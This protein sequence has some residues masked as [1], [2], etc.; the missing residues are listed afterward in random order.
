MKQLSGFYRHDVLRLVEDRSADL[1]GVELGVAEGVFSERMI[2]SGKFRHFFGVDL[3]SDHRHDVAEYKR[4]LQRV[5]LL[6]NYRLLRMSFDEAYDLFDDA[7]LDFVYVDGYAHTGEEGGDTI[8]KWYR[9]VRQGGVIAGDDYHPDWPLVVEAANRFAA[10]A[11]EDLLVTDLTE[12]QEFCRYPTWAIVKKGVRTPSTP[13]HLAAAG[14][15]A[16]VRAERQ[17]ARRRALKNLATGL[18][19]DWVRTRLRRGGGDR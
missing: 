1:I 18:L 5:G 4:A 16:R 2:A 7:S 12:E 10:D 6:S 14:R 15:R 8:Y 9:K 19:P 3:Y 11:S 17:W 13:P